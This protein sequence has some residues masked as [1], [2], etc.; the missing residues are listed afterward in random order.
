MLFSGFDEAVVIDLETTGLDP[1]RDRVV[2]IAMIRSRFADLK[3]NSGMMEAKTMDALVH[4]QRRIPTAA[5]RVNGITDEDVT[6]K[7][8][9]AEIATLLRDFIGE[10]PIIAHN[11]SFDRKFLNAEFRRA[12]VKT[13]ARNRS[14]CT[15]RKFQELNPGRKKSLDDVANWMGVKGRAGPRHG[16]IEDTRITWEIAA[17]FYMMD[18]GMKAT[19]IGWRPTPGVDLPFQD[20]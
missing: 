10:C 19:I 18:H 7:P 17:R 1:Q 14:F 16:A 20:Q 6:D 9:F 4:P 15:M 5:S 2:S 8:P 13:L 12:G 11:V 3:R